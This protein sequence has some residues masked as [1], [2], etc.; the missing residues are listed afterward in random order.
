MDGIWLFLG[1]GAAIG[2]G[3]ALALLMPIMLRG[4]TK[5][6][7]RPDRLRAG[8]VQYS[9]LDANQKKQLARQS[10]QLLERIKITGEPPPVPAIL[11]TGIAGNL[12]LL[13]TKNLGFNGLKRVHVGRA[14]NRPDKAGAATLALAWDQTQTLGARIADNPV[15]RAAADW[16]EKFAAGARRETRW[17]RQFHELSQP[18]EQAPLHATRRDDETSLF[19]A[20]CEAYFQRGPQLAAQHPALFDH[21]RQQFCIDTTT[22]DLAT[23]DNAFNALATEPTNN[24]S[25]YGS[26]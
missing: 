6:A 17:W 9:W 5:A 13:V 10:R 8:V 24:V 3:V 18:I 11:Q 22:I 21:L 15:L 16:L 1:I 26:I 25:I 2:A 20:A 12:A 4:R 23:A 14:G 7:I 19:A